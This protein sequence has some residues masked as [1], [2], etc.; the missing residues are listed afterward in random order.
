MFWWEV[1]LQNRPNCPA[2]RCDHGLG[3]WRSI[4]AL[5]SAGLFEQRHKYYC[6][7]LTVIFSIELCFPRFFTLVTVTEKLSWTSWLFWLQKQLVPIDWLLDLT[8]ICC[9][10]AVLWSTKSISTK[11]RVTFVRRENFARSFDCRLFLFSFRVFYIL[12]F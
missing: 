1:C 2:R 7:I 4:G 12:R 6:K 10:S 3:N 11:Q 8:E 5:W 9:A